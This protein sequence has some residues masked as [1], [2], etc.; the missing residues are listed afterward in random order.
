MRTY[1][2]CIPCF[3]RQA[4]DALLARELREEAD[5]THDADGDRGGV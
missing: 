5:V 2:D 1:L 3:T 4:L